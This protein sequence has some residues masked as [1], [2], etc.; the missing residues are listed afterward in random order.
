MFTF[1]YS[2]N[3]PL[4]LT[5]WVDKKCKICRGLEFYFLITKRTISSIDFFFWNPIGNSEEFRV[6]PWRVSVN[7]F[8]VF[9]YQNIWR[10]IAEFFMGF[11]WEFYKV[12]SQISG[13]FLTFWWWCQKKCVP[14]NTL[15]VL[16]WWLLMTCY[17]ILM[18]CYLFLMTS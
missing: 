12:S 15:F 7:S 1:S 2:L 5:F 9:F 10:V 8:S 11:C 3:A 16:S 4:P 13:A 6:R 17:L 18:T 14:I